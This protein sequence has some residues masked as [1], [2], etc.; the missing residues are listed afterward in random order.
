MDVL[1]GLSQ[2]VTCCSS[3]R[4]GEANFWVY[5]GLSHGLFHWAFTIPWVYPFTIIGPSEK[6]F[7]QRLFPFFLDAAAY[8]SG[9]AGLT[10]RTTDF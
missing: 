7:F 10:F 1:L 5:L 6:G 8:P 2:Q 9:E 3:G 4:L